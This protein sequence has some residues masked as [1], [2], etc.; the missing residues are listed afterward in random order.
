M[1]IGK[2]F[3]TVEELLLLIILLGFFIVIFVGSFNYRPAA[4]FFP[5]LLSIPGTILVLLFLLR[6]Y[7]PDSVRTLMTG[8]GGF[9]I[10]SPEG[11]NHKRVDNQVTTSSRR[12]YLIFAFTISYILFSYLSGFYFSTLI[13]LGTYLYATRR[14]RIYQLIT[15]ILLIVVL[16][17]LVYVFDVAFGFHFN[18]GIL[19]SFP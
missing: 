14:I 9:G 1:K 6:G 12:S 2:S 16:I 5:L 7:L 19:F 11:Q 8:L 13:H 4:R 17:S 18:E 3:Y 15:N 10:G